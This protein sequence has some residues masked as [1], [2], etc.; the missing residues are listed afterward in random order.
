MS[1][2]T[3]TS[4]SKKATLT[5][6]VVLGFTVSSALL[7]LVAAVSIFNQ[8]SLGQ[9]VVLLTERDLP[10]TAQVNQLVVHLLDA[11]KSVSQHSATQEEQGLGDQA[12]Q[13]EEKR[14]AYEHQY[15]Q[16]HTMFAGNAPLLAMLSDANQYAND[17]L[18]LG[19]QHL[20]I[21]TRLVA[22]QKQEALV[23]EEFTRQW[24]LFY[25]D[26]AGLIESFNDNNQRSGT[27]AI[28]YIID[29][30]SMAG[31]FLNQ[32]TAVTTDKKLQ[33]IS[34]TLTSL[35]GEVNNK[36]KGMVALYPN[37]S[38][39]V[40][41]YIDLLDNAAFSEHGL[42]KIHQQQLQTHLKSKQQLQL[43][44]QSVARSQ[45][46]FEK[47]LSQ[48]AHSSEQTAATA[49]QAIGQSLTII[50]VL[51]II[52][53]AISMIVALSVVYNLRK[54]LKN[55][56]GSLRC[57]TGGDLTRQ[58]EAEYTGELGVIGSST[59]QLITTLR[60]MV[61]EISVATDEMNTVVH[62][63]R[64]VSEK[65]GL[66]ADQQQVDVEALALSANNVESMSTQVAEHAQVASR[67]ISQASHVGEE[68]RVQAQKNVETTQH[69]A[70]SLSDA[71]VIIDELHQESQTISQILEVI[72]NIAGQTNLL[73]LNAA[74]EAAR[75]GEQGRGF[76]VVADEVRTLASRTQDSTTEINRM[77][78]RLQ[79]KSKQAVS[80][81]GH[82]RKAA[83]DSV[84]QTHSAMGSLQQIVD[85][86][87]EANHMS[88]AIDKAASDQRQVAANA[89]QIVD[90]LAD[91]VRGMSVDI[92]ELLVNNQRLELRSDE[93]KQ[94]VHRFQI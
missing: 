78:E 84:D 62:H 48:I 69:L 91:S 88:S 31:V 41:T 23:F 19:Q 59:N 17:S 60:S 42:L 28:E 1:I 20:Q 18:S 89:S 67:Q 65:T 47:L 66:A 21:H 64:T 7:L 63:S 49:K 92:E 25:G 24:L 71:S 39:V 14:Q 40:K 85:C 53:I 94:L 22:L 38:P 51:S 16:V 5:Q 27:W 83:N 15:Q 61:A 87:L 3:L 72:E 35:V 44:A 90:L 8:L 74:I 37:E 68:Y 50:T 81:I 6:K 10:Y 86:L 82:S 58:I 75:A 93:L 4:L 55:I 43:L 36:Y 32:I 57:A 12:R 13:F 11:N 30:G 77:I 70:T 46:H 73:A 9:W 56:V 2:F 54:P 52:A 76:A 79:S 33:R 80:I 45:A 34:Q 26:M 29:K